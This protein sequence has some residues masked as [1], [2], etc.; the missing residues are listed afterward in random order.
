MQPSKALLWSSVLLIL[1]ASPP[2]AIGSATPVAG[3]DADAR[4]AWVRQSGTAANDVAYGCATDGEGNIAVAGATEGSL[5]GTNEGESDAFVAKIDPDGN[6]VWIRQL[7]SSAR[8]VAAATAFDRDGNIVIAGGTSG[9]LDGENAGEYDAFVAKFDGNGHH[10]WTRQLGTPLGDTGFSVDSDAQG[11]T[12]IAGDTFGS[13]GG[14]NAGAADAYLAKFDAGGNRLWIQQ[15]GTPAGD[16]IKGIAIDQAGHVY[17]TGQTDGDLG[18]KNAG[19]SDAFLAKYAPDGSLLWTR[20]AGAASLEYANAVVTD[21]NG[22][23]AI[24]GLTNGAL[25]GAN[26]G[27]Y[28]AF[29]IK[30]DPDG[31]LLWTRQLGT[32]ADDGANGV[33]ARS[34]RID[35]TGYTGGSFGGASAGDYDAFL[36]QYTSSGNRVWILQIGSASNDTARDVD[37]DRNGDVYVAGQTDGRLDGTSAGGFDAFVARFTDS[38]S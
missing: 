29:L 25:E 10:L 33:S 16:V 34:D 15:L 17:V 2:D 28:D 11:N 4:L 6:T 31:T 38:S 18:A 24:A 21:D 35:V 3:S 9:N 12:Y 19:Q 5:D 27:G 26:A 13:L 23:V 14:A 36:A 37:A 8:D 1:L 22:D 7:G 20:Q 32:A 30:Y